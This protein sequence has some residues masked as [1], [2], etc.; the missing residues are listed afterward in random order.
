MQQFH[1]PVTV[2][3]I[4]VKSGADIFDAHQLVPV[5]VAQHPHEGLVE[6]QETIVR[7]SHKYA[8][9]NVL[10]Q[11]LI[12]LLGSAPVGDILQHVNNSQG[13]AIRIMKLGGRSEE[14]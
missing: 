2:R 13:L 5:L 7:G 12:S 3:G 4:D 11:V 14:C 9:P 6:I 10:D 8:F 1:Q